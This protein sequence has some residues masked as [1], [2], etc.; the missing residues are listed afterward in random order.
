VRDSRFAYWQFLKEERLFQ[1]NPPGTEKSRWIRDEQDE[2]TLLI[3]AGQDID[4]PVSEMMYVRDDA[5][6]LIRSE[7]ILPERFI[8]A[9]GR[10]DEVRL[11]DGS[12]PDLDIAYHRNG[13]RAEVEWTQFEGLDLPASISVFAGSSGRS[14]GFPRRVTVSRFDPTGKQI[15]AQQVIESPDGVDP[16]AL[17]DGEAYRRVRLS[18]Y[19]WMTPEELQAVQEWNGLY[20]ALTPAEQHLSR[21]LIDKDSDETLFGL[22]LVQEELNSRQNSLGWRIRLQSWLYRGYLFLEDKE[23]F[24]AA[25]RDYMSLLDEAGVSGLNGYERGIRRN[26][27]A[28]P[29]WRTLSPEFRGGVLEFLNEQQ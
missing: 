5:G 4:Y 29:A 3:K 25:Y 17:L 23:G 16:L 12:M 22:S 13:R 27:I 8:P 1:V 28:G 11:L 2:N 9:D 10:I 6:R 18:G 21:A 14:L 20:V 15:V 26:W 7:A 24:V 19:R